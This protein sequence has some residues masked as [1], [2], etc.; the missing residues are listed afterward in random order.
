MELK[1]SKKKL[2][3]VV[4]GLHLNRGYLLVFYAL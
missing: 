2:S 3:Q 1:S 4:D